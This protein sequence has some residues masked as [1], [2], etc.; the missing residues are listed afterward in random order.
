MSRIDTFTES[1]SASGRGLL[2]DLDGTLAD[3]LQLAKQIYREVTASIGLPASDAEFDEFNGVPLRDACNVLARKTA[4]PICAEDLHHRWVDLFRRRYAR[5]SPTP[6]AKDLL[7]T[8]KAAGWC[9][10]IVTSAPA[11]L[12]REWLHVHALGVDAVVGGDD[13]QEG[14]PSPLPYLEAVSRLGIAIE[15]CIAVEDSDSGARAALAAG[16]TTFMLGGQG[17]ALPL[18]RLA[19]LTT[20][21][22]HDRL[23]WHEFSS[24]QVELDPSLPLL[25]QYL[26]AT[27]NQIWDECLKQ[28]PSLFEGEAFCWHAKSS[29]RITGQFIPYRYV[30]AS[31]VEPGLFS[32]FQVRPLA[33]TAVARCTDGYIFGKRSRTVSQAQGL[34]ELGPSGGIDK[35]AL[36]PDSTI[37]YR[38]LILRELAEEMGIHQAFVR[39]LDVRSGIQNANSGLLDLIAD[40]EIGLTAA[41]VKSC[42][43]RQDS[44]EYE[45]LEVV[46]ENDIAA[47]CAR[48]GWRL[49]DASYLLLS[50]RGLLCLGR[51]ARA[52]AK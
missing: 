14:K 22:Q 46:A 6:G 20:L 35:L 43:A 41:E 52:T 49:V 3:S 5:V 1:A 50:R 27:V 16:L 32:D 25:R 37:D 45:T 9:V 48:N 7:A 26:T 12:A 34:W 18:V 40:I 28:R 42:H 30:L 24:L 33:V 44:E 4:A 38:S 2:C 23:I 11:S 39:R 19:D 10:A 29:S 47:F 51:D 8:A 31:Q 36:K 17:P 21:L 15:N 13:V